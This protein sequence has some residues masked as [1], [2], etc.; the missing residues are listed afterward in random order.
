MSADR[1]VVDPVQGSEALDLVQAINSRLSGT[2]LSIRAASASDALFRLDDFAGMSDLQISNQ[3]LRSQLNSAIDVVVHVERLFDGR[4]IVTS[5]SA[6]DSQR[7]QDYRLHKLAK[8]V[9]E[10]AGRDPVVRGTWEY[11]PL[12]QDWPEKFRTVGAVLTGKVWEFAP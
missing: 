9:Q 10:P 8:F 12:P 6:V 3:G 7:R 11:S 2:L 4:R 5:I 1:L